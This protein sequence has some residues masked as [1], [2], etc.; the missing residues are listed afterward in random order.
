MIEDRDLSKWQKLLSFWP[1]RNTEQPTAFIKA[2]EQIEELIELL[3]FLKDHATFGE[4]NGISIG[5]FRNTDEW[6]QE[7][8]NRPT[9]NLTAKVTLPQEIEVMGGYDERDM[10]EPPGD[11][12]DLP[13]DIPKEETPSEK[14]YPWE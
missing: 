6:I 4:G 2:P 11:D 5:L 14:K 9:W 10:V 13:F 1:S 7:N 12:E 3:Q 8:P